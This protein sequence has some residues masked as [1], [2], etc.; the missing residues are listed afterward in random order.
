MVRRKNNVPATPEPCYS[1]LA[2]KKYLWYKLKYSF[3]H[4]AVLNKA[5]ELVEYLVIAQSRGL[6][7]SYKLQGRTEAW[8][9]GPAMPLNSY[10]TSGKPISL[11]CCSFPICSWA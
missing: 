1:H 2:G 4:T 5:S 11:L 8:K 10:V 9:I 6:D 7:L 3:V